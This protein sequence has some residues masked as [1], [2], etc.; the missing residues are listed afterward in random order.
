MK[1]VLLSCVVVLGLNAC[2]NQQEQ[3]VDL[4]TP[5]EHAAG[6]VQVLEQKDYY[7]DSSSI[8][9]DS[10]RPEVINFDMV[11]N[12]SRGQLGFKGNPN[13]IG[14]SVRSHKSVNCKTH[15]YSRSGEMLYSKF[16]GEGIELKQY[17]QLYKTTEIIA[18]SSLDTVA[19]VLCA[20]FYRSGN[21]P[22]ATDAV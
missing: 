1:K 2:T 9:I 17:R 5:N 18:G 3:M 19:K 16:W 14:K 11:T 8:W 22:R 6:F 10:Q 21:S 13:E 20:N 12:L 15:T 7:I 4:I